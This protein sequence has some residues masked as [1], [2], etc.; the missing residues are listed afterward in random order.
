MT[1]NK[2]DVLKWLDDLSIEYELFEHP[3]LPDIEKAMEYWKDIEAFH[4]KNLF[5]RNH[6]GNRHYLVI[7]DHRQHL[8]IRDLELRLKQ[9]KLSFASEKRMAKYLGLSPGSV[10]AFGIIN[11]TENHVYLFLDKNIAKAEKISFH[12]NDNTATLVI[13]GED[14]RR[15]LIHS[16]NPYEFLELY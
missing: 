1:K 3:P 15:F 7:F 5:F 16:G 6:K 9:G 4:C 10:S 2:S 8:N 11:D 13:N 14:F 12:P